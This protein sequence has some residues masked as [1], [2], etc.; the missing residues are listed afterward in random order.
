MIITTRKG[1]YVKQLLIICFYVF[2]YSSV[3]SIN[4]HKTSTA[5]PIV[6]SSKPSSSLSSVQSITSPPLSGVSFTSVLAASKSSC[7]PWTSLLWAVQILQFPCLIYTQTVIT[8]FLI[9]WHAGFSNSKTNAAEGNSILLDCLKNV[10][11]M[12]LATIWRTSF[13]SVTMPI[14]LLVVC[15]FLVYA[16]LVK[17]AL[18]TDDSLST[19]YLL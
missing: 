4:N 18:F 12:A 2:C 5:V 1:I 13:S 6:A 3:Q 10:S 19:Y 16:E 8:P 15:L 14:S 7:L 17:M 9:I 11:A